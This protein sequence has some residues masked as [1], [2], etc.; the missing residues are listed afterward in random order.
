[1]KKT[2]LRGALLWAL[3][4][5]LGSA[6]G[7]EASRYQRWPETGAGASDSWR[8]LARSGEDESKRYRDGR[9]SRAPRPEEERSRSSGAG[10]RGSGVSLDS[11]VD[12]IRAETGARILSTDTAEQNGRRVYD[13]KI[14]TE[15]GRVRRMQVDGESGEVLRGSSRRS[16][17]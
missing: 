2:A 10:R 16:Y 17:R 13:I 12:R 11:A 5:I 4:A 15:D 1:M 8:Y 14:L 7:A 9:R 3:L 6:T